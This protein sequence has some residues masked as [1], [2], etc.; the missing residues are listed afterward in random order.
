MYTL[1]LKKWV[2]NIHMPH[3]HDMAL[4]WGLMVHNERFWAILILVAVLGLLVFFTIWAGIS[5]EF[6]PEQKPADP[7]PFYF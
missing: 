2:H 7:F 1:P 6:N 3:R 4:R 5:G